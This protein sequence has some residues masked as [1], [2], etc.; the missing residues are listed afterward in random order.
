MSRCGHLSE[1]GCQRAWPAGS[2]PELRVPLLG[3]KPPRKRL[4]VVVIDAP[5]KRQHSSVH[6]GALRVSL[7]DVVSLLATINCATSGG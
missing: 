4:A 7:L 1:G 5:G 3:G 6:H 2:R